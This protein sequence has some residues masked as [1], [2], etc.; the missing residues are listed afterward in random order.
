MQYPLLH[1]RSQ[2]G[3]RQERQHQAAMD[4]CLPAIPMMVIMITMRMMRMMVIAEV[5]MRTKSGIQ[6]C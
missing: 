4:I 5:M 3:A 6:I 1:Y 2:Q